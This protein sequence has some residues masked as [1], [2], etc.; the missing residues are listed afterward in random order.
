[1]RGTRCALLCLL[2]L[3]PARPTRA[4]IM[5]DFALEMEAPPGAGCAPV[6]ALQRAVE[7]RIDRLV[8]LGDPAPARRIRV[9]IAQDPT[10]AGWSAQ[11]VMRDER[12]AIV[13]ERRVSSE[14]ARCAALD[15]A[16]VVV[17]STLIG[18]AE[19]APE[20]VEPRPAPL[21]TEPRPSAARERG[22]SGEGRND[23]PARTSSS[24]PAI[25]H[26]A[27]GERRPLQLALGVSLAG[28]AEL[29]L[30]PGV[31]PG[32][33]LE[34]LF[35][36]GVWELLAGASALPHATEALG[37]GASASLR[38]LTGEAGV[39]L[40]AAQPLGATFAFCAGI[41]AGAIE[42]RT[43]GLQA[44]ARR[45][46]PVARALLGPRLRVPLATRLGLIAALTAAAPIAAPRF[47]ILDPGGR[48]DFYHSVGL[49]I[50]GQLGVYWLFFS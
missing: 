4:Q 36:F 29:G 21:P 31:A 47:F 39:C 16:L 40:E 14:G 42:V 11:I 7:A 34:L 20:P 19:P 10:T 15:E 43:E 3:A 12:D 26:D 32:A 45:L 35:D 33:A 44:P 37:G 18:I 24:L 30:L 48:R 38:A 6:E 8:F 22:S 25:T 5:L 23:E 41:Q 13:G 27:A 2:A 49:G 46:E 50:S 17:L 28:R 9:S 1:M